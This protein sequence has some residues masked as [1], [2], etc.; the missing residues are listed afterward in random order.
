MDKPILFSG[1]MVQAIIEGR[2]TQTR[3]VIKPQPNLYR[4]N[5]EILEWKEKNLICNGPRDGL[6]ANNPF[7]K[8]G[9]VIWVRETWAVWGQFKNGAGYC[10]RADGDLALQWRPSIFMPREACRITLKVINVRVEQVQEITDADCYSEGIQDI[11]KGVGCLNGKY[12]MAKTLYAE[13]WNSI[14][15]KRGYSWQ[16]NPWVW[17]IE[18]KPESVARSAQQGNAGD[19]AS[20]ALIKQTL[21][22]EVSG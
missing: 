13:L 17:V 14:N 4:N 10:Y 5:P 12:G 18:F 6:V 1:N 21:S 22:G 3:R 15:A 2:K 7:G 16:S 11:G 8:P 9:G 19:A 20:G